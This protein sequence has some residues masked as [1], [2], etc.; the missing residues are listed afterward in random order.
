MRSRRDRESA[1]FEYDKNWFAHPERFSLEPALKLGPGPFHTSSDRPLREIDYLLMVDDETR[2]GG[3]RW[4][5]R[6]PQERASDNEPRSYL[7]FVIGR[8][9]SPPGGTAPQKTMIA[10]MVV[11]IRDENTEYDAPPEC[12][13]ILFGR[14]AMLPENGIGLRARRSQG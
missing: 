4:R 5:W 2:M 13:H 9:Q 7:E 14:C 12:V 10:Q 11:G 1:T 8:R 3:R 6:S